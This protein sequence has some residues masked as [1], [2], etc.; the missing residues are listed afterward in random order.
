MGLAFLDSV[1]LQG[2]VLL[3]AI[4]AFSIAADVSGRLPVR[5]V[6]STEAALAALVVGMTLPQGVLLLPYLV[7]PSMVA[8]LVLGVWPV[9]ITV[10]IELLSLILVV[11]ASGQ[12]GAIESLSEIVAP[13]LLTTLGVGLLG[14][15]VR[16]LRTDPSNDMDASY[17]SAR[18]LLSQLRTVARRL[19]SG[20]DTVTMSAQLLVTVHD[21]VAD[22]QSAVFV[23]TDGGVLAPLGYRGPQA[24]ESVQAEGRL[25][26]RCWAE[27]AP[28]HELHASGLAERRRRIVLPLRVGSRMIGVVVAQG[29]QAPS[30]ETLSALMRKVDEHALRIETALVFDDI[31][32][33]A[34]REER[35]RLAR[36]I[37]DGIA[38]EIAS[39]GYVVDDLTASTLSEVERSKLQHLRAELSRVVSELRLSIFDLRGELSGGLG[40]TLADYVREMGARSE[41]T[42]HLTLDVAPTRLQGEVETELL[43]IAQEAITNT[44]KHSAAQNLWVDCSIHPPYAR[45]IISDDGQGLGRPRSDSYG[46]KIMRE[47]AER[48]NADLEVSTRPVTDEGSGTVVT[49]TVGAEQHSLV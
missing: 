44:R 29:S 12:V 25:V 19:S 49:I 40:S 20:L 41:L 8:G 23:R 1:A 48:I 34:T 6:L 47:R 2:T 13:W 5:W 7:I 24:R 32:S 31:R 33:I 36:E 27:M 16:R 22:S 42:V 37:H 28:Q 45:I 15:R 21:H 38:Q 11:L 30:P 35:H 10:S 3:T 18:R 43:R 17:E 14:T 4:A 46:L 26:D 9:L 39:L